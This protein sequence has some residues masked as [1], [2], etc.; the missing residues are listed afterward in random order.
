MR[1]LHEQAR[2]RLAEEIHGRPPEY[3]GERPSPPVHRRPDE[4]GSVHE[5]GEPQPEFDDRLT[6]ERVP[7]EGGPADAGKP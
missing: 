1:A 3:G 4:D 2:E 7:E 6:A 5:V